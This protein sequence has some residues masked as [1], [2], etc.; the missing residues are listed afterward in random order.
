MTKIKSMVLVHSAFADGSGWKAVADIL[1]KDGY[2]VSVA[3]PP[4]TGTPTTKKPAEAAIDA[5]DGPVVLVGHSYGGSIITEAGN[6]PNVA[7]ALVYIAAFALDEGESCRID[8]TGPAAERPRR[9][10]RTATV[11]WIDE[12]H[13]VA[14]SQRTF[15]GMRRVAWLYRSADLHRRVHP[16]GQEPGL[17]AQT[18]L[19]HGC[20][21]RPI[22]QSGSGSA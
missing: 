16:S 11:W 5:M 3:Q 6:H 12:A 20:Q 9:S 15:H 13:F 1:K 21:R 14:T 2:K 18:Y 22:D 7:A 4:G 17:E 10:N 19:V 8:R